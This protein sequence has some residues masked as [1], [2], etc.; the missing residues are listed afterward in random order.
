MQKEKN[1]PYVKKFDS[2]GN[3]ENPITK[4]NPYLNNLTHN[5][6]RRIRRGTNKIV[7]IKWGDTIKAVLKR[8]T[9]N[10]NWVNA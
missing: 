3:I 2:N 5:S 8:K 4:D 1:V 10:G 9:S 6:T 7:F